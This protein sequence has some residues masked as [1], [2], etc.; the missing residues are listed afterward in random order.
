MNSN[1]PTPN[2]PLS[3]ADPQS[4]EDLFSKDPLELTKEERIVI[5]KKLREAR[6]RWQEEETATKSGAK[7]RASTK[8]GLKKADIANIDLDLDNLDLD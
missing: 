3:D 1:S 6:H 4:L 8:A 5:I 2:S 7:K